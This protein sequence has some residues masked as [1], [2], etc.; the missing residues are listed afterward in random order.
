M[1][2]HVS[3]WAWRQEVGDDGAKLVLLK[4]ADSANDDGV[5][6]P[7]RATMLAECEAGHEDTIKAR[8]RRLKG[9]GL[10]IPVPWYDPTGRQTS[11]MYVLP[12][13]GELEAGELEELLK[14]ADRKGYAGNVVALGGRGAS[15]HPSPGPTGG[16]GTHPTR[17][18]SDHPTGGAPAHPSIED[19]SEDPQEEPLAGAKRRRSR[20]SSPSTSPTRD[21]RP[22]L[23]ALE[24]GIGQKVPRIRS[25]AGQWAR[26][27]S[28]LYDAGHT[29]AEV[30][31]ACDRY[32][33]HETLGKCILTPT[34]L[35]SRWADVQ[36]PPAEVR[37]LRAACPECGTGGGLHATGCTLTAAV[38]AGE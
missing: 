18:A 34:A 10:I 28:E 29:P 13:K 20:A 23:E 22:L 25:A 26:A 4:L 15:V 33:R 6:W 24:Q 14:R 16:D 5:A 36:P 32:R 11:S 8:I 27:A 9:S 21:L 37:Q 3:S 19:P 17:G 1:S 7:S 30:L 31:E 38:A 2:V 12:F 35:V